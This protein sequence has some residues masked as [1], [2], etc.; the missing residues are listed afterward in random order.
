MSPGLPLEAAEADS[1]DEA[2][3]RFIGDLRR[4][5]RRKGPVL[6]LTLPPDAA[7]EPS[8]EPEMDDAALGTALADV[9]GEAAFFEDGALC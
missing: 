8:D 2:V 3:E 7:D 6:A 1:D 9:L 4:K 5:I